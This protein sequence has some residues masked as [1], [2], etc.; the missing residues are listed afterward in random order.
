MKRRGQSAVW[1]RN[2]LFLGLL[3]LGSVAL[4][5]GL[6]PRSIAAHSR[7][8]LPETSVAD[9]ATVVEEINRQFRHRWSEA[10]LSPAPPAPDLSVARRL[11]LALT[12]SSPSLQEIRLL[13]AEPGGRWLENWLTALFKD[14][15]FTDYF[16]ERLAR[17]YVGTED[18]PFI[19]YRRRRFVSWLS[20]ELL[21]NRPY[22]EIVR[23]LIADEGLWTDKP[24][25]N[26]VTVT[27]EQDKNQPNAERLAARV[28]RAFLGIRLDCAQCHDHPFQQWKQKDFQGLAAYFGQVHPGFTG[29]YDGDGEFEAPRRRGGDSEAVVPRVPFHPEALPGEGSRRWQLACWVTDRRNP[30]FAQATVNRIWALLLGRPLVEPVDDLA[31]EGEPPQ[32]LQ[33]LASDFTAHGYDLQHLIRVITAAEVF[34]LDSTAEPELTAAHE[35]HWAAF[36]LTR[37]RPEQV[38]GA[39]YQAASVETLNRDSHILFRIVKAAGENEFVKRY[40][41]VGEDEF[42][43]RPG[44]IPQRL[45]L[46]NG[47]LVFDSLE[48]GMLNSPGMISR[49]AAD[50]RK[51]VEAT[52]LTVLTRRPTPEEAAHFQARLGCATGEDRLHRVSDLFW[53][54][55]NTTEFSWNH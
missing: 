42:N 49:L 43:S 5:G 14:R 48:P 17:A 36:P 25:T 11:S 28:T 53:T 20:D 15:R 50:D 51:A 26:F 27:V 35:E 2:L 6:F 39:V 13:E 22:D 29:I 44:T 47:Q 4:V 32:V 23:E 9:Y 12:G 1:A 10:Q 40:G 18:G 45:L 52:Y 54:L 34:H 33:I 7:E 38:A 19:I 30:A 3:G 41:D 55:V 8:K 24:A 16:A 31:S 46:M 37:L 21:K